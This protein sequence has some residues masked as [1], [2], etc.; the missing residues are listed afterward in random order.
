MVTKNQY[1]VWGLKTFT[2][3]GKRPKSRREESVLNTLVGSH[4]KSAR[5]C[6]ETVT[7]LGHRSTKQK[8]T[9]SAR[10]E[11]QDR[12]SNIRVDQGREGIRK[13]PYQGRHRGWKGNLEEGSGIRSHK[14]GLLKREKNLTYHGM[15]RKDAK[16]RYLPIGPKKKRDYWANRITLLQNNGKSPRKTWSERKPLKRGRGWQTLLATNGALRRSPKE[17]TKRTRVRKG[18]KE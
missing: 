17:K 3:R 14:A 5:V 4:R 13:N 11:T 10:V 7:S 6:F 15:D 18:I 8:N 9:G 12:K 2:T 16:H 1:G